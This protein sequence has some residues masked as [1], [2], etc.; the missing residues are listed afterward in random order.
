LRFPGTSYEDNLLRAAW[1]QRGQS[2]WWL[3]EVGL[4]Y[5][6]EPPS[7]SDRRLDALI[8]VDAPAK[9][10]DKGED[11]D[12][13]SEVIEAGGTVELVEAKKELNTNV[14]GQLLCGLSMFR[15]KYEGRDPIKM[16]AVVGRAEDAAL[17]WYCAQEGIEVVRVDPL[18][19][20][21]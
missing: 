15:A 14:L 13:M 11:L 20:V 19:N 5:P 16:T 17:S 1:V 18:L 21:P 8:L 10:S 7:H 6:G 2:G 9:V 3:K 12:E 4:G